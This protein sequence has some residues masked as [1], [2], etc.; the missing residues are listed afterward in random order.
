MEFPRAVAT[1]LLESLKEL[2][3]VTISFALLHLP[4]LE[5]NNLVWDSKIIRERA[6]HSYR[7]FYQTSEGDGLLSLLTTVMRSSTGESSSG[8][9]LGS[10]L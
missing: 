3:L 9:I 2:S 10:A 5:I 7:E 8:R 6:A 1:V 4:E